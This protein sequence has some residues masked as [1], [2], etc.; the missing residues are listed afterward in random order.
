MKWIKR[1]LQFVYSIYAFAL[2]IGM[3]FL[4]IPLAVI[5]SFFGRIRGGNSIYR[6]LGVWGDAWLFCIGIF[7]KNI[8]LVPH[9]K[10]HACI[11]VINHTSYMDIPVLVKSLRQPVRVLGKME[12]SKIPVFGF[13]YRHAT[14]MV[15]RSNVENRARSVK[16][17][18]ALLK[19]NIS[20]VIFPE[21]TFNMTGQPL[22]DFYNGA[23]KIAV[24]TQT[25]VKPVIFPDNLDRLHFRSVFSL[26][27]GI[28][29][30]IY[31]KE[32]P[33]DGLT[34]ADVERLKQEVYDKM[35]AELR[36]WRKYDTHPEKLVARE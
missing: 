36:K 14:V 1:V 22:K 3:M 9:S 12:M 15:D 35:D 11:F 21:G 18:K 30:A 32:I 7:H 6:M 23:F 19:K 31:M 28:S 2:F 20:V 29:R 33:V 25:P 5:A 4:V 8:Y 27:P 24:E 26:T 16:S 34:L 10:D 17:L 13:L